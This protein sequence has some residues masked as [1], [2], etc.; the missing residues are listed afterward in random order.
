MYHKQTV[1]V[2]RYANQTFDK[3]MGAKL[4]E[5]TSKPKWAYQLLEFDGIV[6][7]GQFWNKSCFGYSF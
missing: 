4:D 1:T 5:T 6:A 3:L 7:P 2:K